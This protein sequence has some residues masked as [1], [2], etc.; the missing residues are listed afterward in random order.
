MV[1]TPQ[2]TAKLAR[3]F[4]DHPLVEVPLNHPI[5]HLVYDFPKGIPKVH[6]HD[7]KPAQGFG[8]FLD[9]RLAVYYD[10]QTDLGDGWEDYEVHHDPPPSTGKRCEWVSTCSRPR[11]GMA[12]KWMWEHSAE[13]F[14][15]RVPHPALPRQI[16]PRRSRATF[17]SWVSAI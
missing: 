10:Y 7:G 9:G 2:S 4:P 3:V 12:G 6:E 17:T 11:W 8:I 5:Y 13:Q 15:R 16:Q 1:W 14:T